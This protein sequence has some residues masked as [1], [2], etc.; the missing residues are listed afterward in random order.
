MAKRKSRKRKRKRL[1]DV[2]SKRERAALLNAPSPKSVLGIRARAILALMS[3]NGLRVGE[4]G[5]G[6][7]RNQPGLRVS[8][9]RLDADDPYIRV[10]GKGNKERRCF[11]GGIVLDALKEWNAVRP[12]KS[13]ALFP[14]I[15][16]GTRTFGKARRDRA[17]SVRWIQGMVATYAKRAG[18][19]RHIHPHTLRHT[20]ATILLR[21]G[22][23]IRR[24]QT[25]L[26]HSDIS[27]T[28]IY[29]EIGD[30][31]IAEMMRRAASGQAVAKG[32]GQ[33]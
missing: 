30:P 20:A 33:S 23:N 4:I 11:I 16:G 18:I 24:I 6:N 8:D 27:T 21:D 13:K 26:G 28:Q 3:I 9:L 31:E 2:L 17:V 5:R 14:V 32:D 29:T 19:D 22:E 7:K 10:I 1:P 12:K 25:V 15:Q